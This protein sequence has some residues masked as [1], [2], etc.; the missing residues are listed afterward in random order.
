[1]EYQEAVVKGDKV[2]LVKIGSLVPYLFAI[3]VIGR[4][5]PWGLV[6]M[7]MNT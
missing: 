4:F 3:L 2:P 5:W 1:M 6:E 7:Y